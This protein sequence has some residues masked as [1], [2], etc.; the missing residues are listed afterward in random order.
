MKT[1]LI[2][3]SLLLFFSSCSLWNEKVNPTL[4]DKWKMVQTCG[5]FAGRVET[6]QSLGYEKTVEFTDD[7]NYTFFKNGQIENSGKFAIIKDKSIYSGTEID[8]VKFRNINQKQAILYLKN[9]TLIL[10]DNFYDGYVTTYV[11]IT[12]N[13]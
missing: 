1:N 5:G 10:G 11:R 7:N 4:I 8:F 6:P 2:V 9:D 13:R 12:L 3:F